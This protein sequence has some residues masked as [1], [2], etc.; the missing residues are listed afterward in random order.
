[1]KKVL[2]PASAVL[3]ALVLLFS[4]SVSLGDGEFLQRVT[5]ADALI[6]AGNPRGAL[7]ILNR[8]SR[9][10]CS[11]IQRAG[12]YRRY[13]ALSEDALGEKCL[14]RG[15]RDM[16]GN[17]ELS[18]LLAKHLLDRGRL[19]EAVAAA[20]SLG[21]TRYDSLAAEIRLR[22]AATDGL[23]SSLIPLY[24]SAWRATG[25]SSWLVN[26]ALVSA[27][28]GEI[29]Q[30]ASLAPNSGTAPEEALF[31]ASILL[32]G[33]NEEAALG[34]AAAAGDNPRALALAA[35]ALTRL[36]DP[37]GGAAIWEY[38]GARYP[39]GAP[40]VSR[41]VLWYNLARRAKARQ[42]E[43][44]WYGAVTECVNASEGARDEE[45]LLALGAYGDFAL[46]QSPP[47]RSSP[48]EGALRKSGLASREMAL[49]E[50]VPQAGGDVLSRMEGALEKRPSLPLRIEYLKFLLAG[51]ETLAA[52]GLLAE[53]P[54]RRS[55][56][57]ADPRE[58]WLWDLLEANLDPKRGY[59][60]ELIRFAAAYLWEENKRADADRL[61]S[62]YFLFRHDISLGD[63][64]D[65]VIG[66][67][68]GLS[69][70]ECE[71]LGLYFLEHGRNAL[72]V[73]LLEYAEGELMETY[74]DLATDYR[75]V[76]SFEAMANLWEAYIALG[77]RDK[78]RALFDRTMLREGDPGRRAE[79][80]FRLGDYQAAGGDLQ[81]ARLSLEDCLALEPDHREARVLQKKIR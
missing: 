3:A 71:Y 7:K 62:M 29:P 24:A 26:A 30:A 4:C 12:L 27:L 80:L 15:L 18:A 54:E 9:G 17:P 60:P 52:Q 10:S 43:A 46:H 6:T 21:G 66:I 72:G 70:W 53:N 63:S 23:D 39:G 81:G 33:G 48:L 34:F 1:V 75:Y 42:D 64:P 78:A 32:D 47:C 19:P 65:R 68:P 77:E 73:R 40:G 50:A 57:P 2:P 25:N 38:L 13:L 56:D 20:E 14:L 69:S 59:P 58:P 35:D 76:P 36:G 37:E 79:L 49:A 11:A 44:A 22:S 74:P 8:L 5:R 16:G 67:L 51:R 28:D 45:V 31:W 61:L 41:V 55:V